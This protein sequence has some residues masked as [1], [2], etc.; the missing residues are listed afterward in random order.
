MRNY[1]KALKEELETCGLMPVFEIEVED[2][3]GNRGFILCNISFNKDSLQA[4]RDAVS[5][6]EERSKFIATSK[7][8]CDPEWTLDEHLADLLD[9]IE[10]DIMDGDLFELA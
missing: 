9:E 8:A 4:Q 6:K 10:T 7:L 3:E 2:M 1:V 5:T